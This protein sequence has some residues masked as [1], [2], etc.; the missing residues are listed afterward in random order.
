ML[1][2]E[3]EG[4]SGVAE[5]D[6]AGV[7]AVVL[8]AGSSSR[9]GRPKQT[10]QFRG[11]SLLRR[12]AL[13]ALG[14]GCRPVIV[15]TGANAELSRRE[16]EGLD[17]REVWNPLWETGMASSIRAGVEALISADAAADVLLLCDQPHVNADVIA[18]LTEAHRATGSP[19]V[20]SAYGGSF[21]APAL[22]GRALFDEL[23][24]LEG[25]AGA[26]QVIKRHASEAHFLPFP[27]GEVDLDTPDDFSR[28][29][30]KGVEQEQA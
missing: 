18:R 25:A 26:K 6:S 28:L 3:A 27:G 15:V 11:E 8:A 12:A 14:A 19:L 9:M 4:I 24:R 13:A 1:R 30:A 7:G 21:G 10:L 20:A 16:L 17:V 23:A 5:S 29:I 22:L 2:A